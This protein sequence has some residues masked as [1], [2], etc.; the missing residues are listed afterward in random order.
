MSLTT[1]YVH[2][3]GNKIAADAL[4]RVWDEA[5]FERD[6]GEATR[7]AYWAPLRYPQPLPGPEFDEMQ[8]LPAPGPFESAVPPAQPPEAFIA[9]TV[10]GTPA[11][12]AGP[13]ES[14]APGGD[15]DDGLEPWLRRMTYQ[16]DALAAGGGDPFEAL[17]LP[18]SMRTAAFRAMVKLTFK[19]VH[20]YFFG[21][22]R[23]AIR[24]VVRESLRGIDG[25]LVVVGHSLGSIIA[26]DVL[27][28][29]EF[30]CLDI[31]LLLTVGSPL[32]ITEVQDLVARPLEVPRAAAAWRNVCDG[33]DFVAL[34][35]TLRPAYAP[36]ERCTDFLVRN[37]SANHHGI[38]E[39]LRSAPV[40]EPI[41][42]LAALGSPAR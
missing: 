16:A 18:R 37:S 34:D 10:A 2:G 14:T 8:M 32:G 20:A 41:R 7:M 5:L 22:V 3:N 30:D 26:Y 12:P 28:E 39:Y 11:T 31:P 21:A 33:F 17:P 27:R 25:P 9:E 13:F 1:V 36:A 24:D 35:K 19:D 29:P 15:G 4:K 6:M 42:E 38:R 23:E 40:R